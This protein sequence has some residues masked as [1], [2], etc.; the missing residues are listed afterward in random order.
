MATFFKNKVEKS[1]GT[2]R[3]PVYEA[4]PSARATVIGLSLANLTSS[5]VS[6]SVLIADDTS[7]VGYYLKDVLIPPNSTLKVLNGGEKIILG[8]TNILYVESDINDSLDCVMSFVE[9]V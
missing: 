5:V 8:S 9:I 7:V 2:V 4:P 1:I 6:A 3:V